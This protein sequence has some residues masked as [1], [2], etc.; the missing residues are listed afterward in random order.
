MNII[1]A[2][3]IIVAAMLAYLYGAIPFGYIATY[4]LKHKKLTEE[5]TGNIGVTNAHKVGGMGA[6]IVTIVGEISKATLPILAGKTLFPDFRAF[7][8]LLVFCALIGTSFSVFLRGKGGKGSTLAFWSILI[9]SANTFFILLGSWIILALCAR[10]N[11][12]IKK[13]QLLCIPC[14]IYF[15]ERDVIFTVF[16][17]LTS[18]LFLITSSIRKDDFSHYH[19]FHQQENIKDADSLYSQPQRR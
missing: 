8:L 17:L 5:G 11:I 1:Q 10:R 2:M 15:V 12:F 9:L 7:T 13:L 18:A 3:E 19:V 14:A 4:L 16:G 6:G